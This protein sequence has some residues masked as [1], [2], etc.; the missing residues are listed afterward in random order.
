VDRL[1]DLGPQ[2]VQRQGLQHEALRF[3]EQVQRALIG[4]R[5]G[6]DQDEATAQSRAHDDRLSPQPH[7]AVPRHVQIGDHSVEGLSP[8]DF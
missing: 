4:Q 7:P 3:E 2:R 8:E 5:L 1:L 6:R